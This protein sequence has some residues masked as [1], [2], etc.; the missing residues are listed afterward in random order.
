MKV[1]TMVEKFDYKV[2][3]DEGLENDIQG[4]FT[5]DLLSWVMA[6]GNAKDAW[7]TVQSHL[8]TIAVASLLE[9]SCIIL[10]S[11]VTISDDVIQKAKEEQIPIIQASSESYDICKKFVEAGI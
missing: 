5:C 1:S 2:I 11:G 4:V 8:N 3:A 10:P 7:I 6:K 9:F